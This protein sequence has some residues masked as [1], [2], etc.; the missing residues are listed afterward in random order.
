MDSEKCSRRRRRRGTIKRVACV[1]ALL[2]AAVAAPAQQEDQDAVAPTGAAV[3]DAFL[4]DVDKLSAQ[5]R[6][7]TWTADHELFETAVG[8]MALKR[9]NRFYWHQEPP[10]ETIVV[11]DGEALWTYDVELAQVAVTRL[12][13]LETANFALLLAGDENLYESFEVVQSD[14]IDDYDWV[15]LA[16][17]TASADFTS[18]RIAFS[19]GLPRQLELVDGLEQ[20]TRI[21]FSDVVVNAELDES[22][23]EFDPP[24]GADVIGDPD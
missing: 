11:A 5:F 23:F 20:T 9:P 7:E 13:E 15:K 6:Q 14:R 18:V 12:D 21:E 19:E 1:V 10:L 24:A 4:A 17:K 3:L 8:T 22:L 16:P 2:G